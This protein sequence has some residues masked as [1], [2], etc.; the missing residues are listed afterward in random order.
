MRGKN[1]GE[2][3]RVDNPVD[4]P[5]TDK[6]ELWKEAIMNATIMAPAEYLKSV[7]AL[8]QSKRGTVVSEEFI[9]DGKIITMVWQIPLSELITDFFDKLKS[10]SQ[11]YASLDYEHSHWEDAVI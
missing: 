1:S 5:D 6:V 4:C 2:L 10:L 9:S 11:G 3:I 7:K 8:C